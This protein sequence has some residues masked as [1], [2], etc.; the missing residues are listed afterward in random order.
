V[1]QDSF[2]FISYL[3]LTATITPLQ[4]RVGAWKCFP[5][6]FNGTAGQSPTCVHIF[7]CYTM[8]VTH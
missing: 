7:V 2:F 4:K 5:F 6:H 1:L 8:S 3:G